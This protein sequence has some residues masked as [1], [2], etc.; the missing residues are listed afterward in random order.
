MAG[1]RW[2]DVHRQ[3]NCVLLQVLLKKSQINL[4]SI[5]NLLNFDCQYN[6]ICGFG[7][8]RFCVS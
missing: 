7:N 5:E 2:Q 6:R 1:G 4:F 3:L 8:H